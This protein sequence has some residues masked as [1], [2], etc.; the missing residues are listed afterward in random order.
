MILHTCVPMTFY[1][2]GR[3]QKY[4]STISVIETRYV[5][6]FL[7]FIESIVEC[8]WKKWTHCYFP[9]L[10]VEQK[11]HYTRRN[12]SIGDIVI[13]YDKDL[14][15]SEWKLGR[16]CEVIEG[17]DKVIRRIKIQ[18]RNKGCN[19]FTSI[20]RSIQRVIVILPIGEQL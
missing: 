6:D 19:Q 5:E 8:F 9:S 10:L 20:T 2:E 3:H 12:V 13:I 16:V 17:S 11:W 4:L 7:S 14:A 1:W 15:R 18:Y